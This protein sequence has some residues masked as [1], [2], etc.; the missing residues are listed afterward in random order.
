MVKKRGKINPACHTPSANAKRRASWLRTVYAWCPDRLI[1]D[2]RI[3]V[4]SKGIRAA[5]ARRMIEAEIT[6]FERS[7]LRVKNG[8]GI[9]EIRPLRSA[10]PQ[11]SL[12][13]VSPVYYD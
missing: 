11:F 13:G 3:L 9:T 6:P 8:S 4:R 1:P 5:E 2:Y 7:L 10:E 12:T